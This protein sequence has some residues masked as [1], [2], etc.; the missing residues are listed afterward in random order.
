MKRLQKLTVNLGQKLWITWGLMLFGLGLYLL[1]GALIA[2]SLGPGSMAELLTYGIQNPKGAMLWGFG[3]CLYFCVTL[4][5]FRQVVKGI[6][7]LW[8]Y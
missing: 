3:F 1:M 7:R 2:G 4:Y 6:Y 5:I 8:H